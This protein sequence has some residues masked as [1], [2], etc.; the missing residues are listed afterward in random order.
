MHNTEGRKSILE[1]IESVETWEH[2]TAW[3]VPGTRHLHMA[4]ALSQRRR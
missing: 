1:E 3:C 2:E 4:A